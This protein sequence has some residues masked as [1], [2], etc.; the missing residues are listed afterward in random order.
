MSQDIDNYVSYILADIDNYVSY[1]LAVV[2]DLSEY[3]L[4]TRYW[5]LELIPKVFKV[6]YLVSVWVL[7]VTLLHTTWEV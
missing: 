2:Y 4:S 5:V 3:T 7:K 1:V 6:R